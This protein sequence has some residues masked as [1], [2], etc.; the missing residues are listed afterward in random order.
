MIALP[1]FEK[2]ALK[3]IVLYPIDLGN[4]VTDNVSRSMRGRPMKANPALAKK[5]IGNLADLSK[6][7][8][9]EIEYDNGVGRIRVRGSN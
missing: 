5:I 4:P 7:F 3:E 2:G 8:G 6:P 9:T 1:E